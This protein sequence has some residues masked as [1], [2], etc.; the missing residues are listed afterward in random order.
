[1]PNYQNGSIYEIYSASADLRY[2]G[3]TTQTLAQR[4]G[5]HRSSMRYHAKTGK[6]YTTSFEV[7]QHPDAKIVLVER[8]PCADK[9]ALEQR[10]MFYIRNNI[11]VNKVQVGRTEA[12]YYIDNKQQ[13]LEYGE[14]YRTNNRE[15]AKSYAKQYHID[16]K[17][18]LRQAFKQYRIDN[19]EKI[20]ARDS[21]KINCPCGSTHRH[22]DKARH[23]RS[24]KHIE[25]YDNPMR[26]LFAQVN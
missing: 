13:R 1:M 3:S 17:I 9:K 2:Y 10:E 12:Q 6:K 11:C 22:G 25:F 16:N 19:K 21:R 26:A 15:K 24:K 4:L 20:K 18:K 8:C 7:L 23:Q 14:Q 5:K